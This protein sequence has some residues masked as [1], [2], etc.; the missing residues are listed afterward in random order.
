MI[1]GS[2]TPSV[3]GDRPSHPI[4][5][6]IASV[7]F[8]VDCCSLRPVSRHYPVVKGF[9]LNS[10]NF[11]P[12]GVPCTIGGMEE[13]PSIRFRNSWFI[14]SSATMARISALPLLVVALTGW[15]PNKELEVGPKGPWPLGAI[16]GLSFIVIGLLGLLLPWETISKSP[17]ATVVN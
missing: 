1:I 14:R 7:A 2:L 4:Y 3:I 15:I 9:T 16:I 17:S 12:S 11:R 13:V 6:R 5:G 10:R 8:F